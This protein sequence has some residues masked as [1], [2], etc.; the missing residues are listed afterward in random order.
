MAEGTSKT[1]PW[2]TFAF[3]GALMFSGLGIL[4]VNWI[5]VADLGVS[6]AQVGLTKSQLEEQRTSIL[7]VEQH[8]QEDVALEHLPYLAFSRDAMIYLDRGKNGV[9]SLKHVAPGV[10]KCE[11][12]L[13]EIKNYGKGAAFDIEVRWVLNGHGSQLVKAQESRH[14]ASGEACRIWTFPG[15][16]LKSS[17]ANC[18]GL[19]IIDY[20]DQR[21]RSLRTVQK[22]K[23]IHDFAAAQ[24]AIEF[25][26]IAESPHSRQFGFDPVIPGDGVL[27]IDVNG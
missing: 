19:A 25:V 11:T 6:L 3:P 7:Q 10:V 13:P 23:A 5:D 17:D 9:L 8:H 2:R 27:T 12:G 4:T 14:L 21:G 22:F 26:E 15:Q 1:G 18:G 16:G 20:H 24:L